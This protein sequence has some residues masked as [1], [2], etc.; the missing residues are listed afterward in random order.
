MNGV[1][2][3]SAASGIQLWNG[4]APALPIAPIAI[5]RNATAPS[6][7]SESRVADIDSVPAR[8]P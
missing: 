5:S 8:C 2:A 3:S 4:M 6:P 7:S 1:G